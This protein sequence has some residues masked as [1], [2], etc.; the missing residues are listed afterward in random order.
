MI[1]LATGLSAMATPSAVLGALALIPAALGLTAMIV[2]AAGGAL[3]GVAGPLIQAGLTSLSVGLT[4]FGTAAANPMVW[5]GIGLL[6]S[7]GAALIPLG[8]AL[9]LAAP[10]I[11]AFGNAI[12][13][14]FEGIGTIITA[15]ANGIAT[16]FGSLEKVDVMKLLAIGPALIG[17]GLGLASLGGGGILGAIGAFLSGDPIEKLQSLAAAGDGLTQTATAL[18][19]IAGALIGVSVALA[20]IDTSKLTALDEFASNRSTDSIVGGITDFITAPIKAV[21]EAIGGKDKEKINT[22]IDLTPMIAAINGV[23]ASID[24]LYSKDQSINMDGKKVGTTLVQN[25]YKSA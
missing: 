7:F 21:G 4:T 1:G 18:Q 20:T 9:K 3:L 25:S 23:K 11:E 10:G 16:I 17:I 2:G 15:A 8:Y 12:K 13:S 5:A 19:A 22:G 24:R 14:T 6:A